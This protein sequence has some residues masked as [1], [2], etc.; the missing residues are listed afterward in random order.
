MP[1]VFIRKGEKISKIT[2]T[3][4]YAGRIYDI[5]VEYCGALESERPDFI[6]VQTTELMVEW[7][8][9]G[10]LGSGGKFYRNAGV[11]YV[12]CYPEDATE[13]R[14]SIINRVN[15]KL[16]DLHQEYNRA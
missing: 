12:Q 13:E 16:L 15:L 8:F 11:W 5:L 14:W 9:R 3:D 1:A 7:R 2:L 4:E 10:L 6:Y